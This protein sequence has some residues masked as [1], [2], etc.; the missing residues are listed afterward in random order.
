MEKQEDLKLDQFY[1]KRE[2][3]QYSRT[4]SPVKDYI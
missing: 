1:F 2:L 3:D 4:L